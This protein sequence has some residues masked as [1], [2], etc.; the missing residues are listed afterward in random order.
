MTGFLS[1]LAGG[2]RSILTGTATV[3]VGTATPTA[4]AIYYGFGGP[5]SFS[6]GSISPANWAGSGL[7]VEV[8]SHV[9]LSAPFSPATQLNFRVTGLAPNYGWETLSIGGTPFSRSSASYSYDGT[10]SSWAFPGAANPFGTTIGATKAI[11][12]S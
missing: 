10:Y 12:W 6:F 7:L 1:V 5:S 2:N 3:T 11:I 9:T 4:G 8:L